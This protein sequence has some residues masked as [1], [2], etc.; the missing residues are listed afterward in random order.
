MES[1]LGTHEHMSLVQSGLW[2][3]VVAPPSQNKELSKNVHPE[4]KVS[5]S[6]STIWSNLPTMEFR[7]RTD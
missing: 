3:E 7:P 6:Y 1:S 5:S 4:L 2:A